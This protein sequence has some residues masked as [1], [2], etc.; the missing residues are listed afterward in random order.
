[1][2]ELRGGHI[3]GSQF[4]DE[5]SGGRGTGLRAVRCRSGR[6]EE[7][8]KRSMGQGCTQNQRRAK[9]CW[10]RTET[11]ASPPSPD[12][13]PPRLSEGRAEL[14]PA[15]RRDL[16]SG[17]LKIREF[18]DQS[19]TFL[20]KDPQISLGYI[21]WL[22]KIFQN[23]FTNFNNTKSIIQIKVTIFDKFREQI[24]WNRIAN[25]I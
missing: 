5:T 15:I 20:Q 1:M 25:T 4:L 16:F 6:W 22:W 2:V 3:T 13:S 17:T 8:R 9:H 12:S 23:N 7:R 18:Y 10:N 19:Y 14:L 11:H 24:I 21:H